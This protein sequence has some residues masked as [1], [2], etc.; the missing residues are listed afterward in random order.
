MRECRMGNDTNPPY[1]VQLL[2]PIS[3]AHYLSPIPVFIGVAKASGKELFSL[4]NLFAVLIE[5]IVF[6]P[7]V[8][9]L[10]ALNE[11]RYLGKDHQANG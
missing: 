11:R 10:R 6:L 4:W 9:I 5:L 2:W 8:G 3:D 7:F 1:G